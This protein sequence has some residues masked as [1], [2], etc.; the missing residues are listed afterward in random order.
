MSLFKIAWKSIRQR[1]LSSSLTSL[2]VALGVMMMVTVIVIYAIINNLFSQKGIGYDLI[3][4]KKGSDLQL[5]LNTVYRL[6]QPVG[7]LPYRYYLTLKDDP[8]VEEAIPFCLGDVTEEGGFPIVGTNFRF[9]EIEYAPG[10]YFQSDGH[11]F[12]EKSLHATI[13]SE[14]ARKNNW[15]I[16][17]TFRL[18]HAGNADHIHDEKFKVVGILHPTGTANDKTVFIPLEA[19]YNIAGHGSPQEE[20]ERHEKEFFGADYEKVLAK[21]TDEKYNPSLDD[22]HD[23]DHGHD[24]DHVHEPMTLT[25]KEVTA[26]LLVMKSRTTAVMYSGAIK[27]GNKAQ[28]VNPIIIISRL[29]N[30]IVGNIRTVLLFLTALIILVSGVGIFVS[31]YNSMSDRKKEIAIMRALGASRTTV[32]S[33]ILMESTLLCFLG[34]VMGIVLAHGLVLVIA[35]I[36]EARSGILMNPYNFE[37]AELIIL[38]V[39]IVLASLVGFIPGMTAYRTDVAETLSS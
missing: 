26:V 29:M 4:G 17:S 36:V 11:A 10:K 20:A 35:P 31:I 33:V 32:F 8:Q 18:S 39:M 21:Y 15:E 19:F 3:V 27:K 30:Q 2:S 1:S 38:P 37:P 28:A 9:F 34:G 22:H 23:H 6:S 13:G 12:N 25:K 14:V 5:V 24:H 16:G 7:N